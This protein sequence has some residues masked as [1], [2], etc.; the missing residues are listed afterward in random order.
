MENDNRVREQALQF[1]LDKRRGFVKVYDS[2]TTD[3]KYRTTH[4][5][6]LSGM[7]YVYKR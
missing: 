4:M 7:S 5:L 2:E 1:S 6:E 3:P